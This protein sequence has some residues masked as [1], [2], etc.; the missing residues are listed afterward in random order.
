M[1]LIFDLCQ[2]WANLSRPHKECRYSLRVL[3]FSVMMHLGGGRVVA[4]R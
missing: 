3:I 4:K 2:Q 1:G